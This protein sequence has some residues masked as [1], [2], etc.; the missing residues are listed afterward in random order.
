MTEGGIPVPVDI[1][2]DEAKAAPATAPERVADEIV[3]PTHDEIAE[4]AYSYWEA[5]GK[6]NGSALEDWVRAEREL[7]Q[8]EP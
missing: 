3:A 2:D 4:L 5:R 7:K 1:L 8:Y 6:P